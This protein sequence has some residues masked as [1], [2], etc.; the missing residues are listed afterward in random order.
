MFPF[1]YFLDLIFNINNTGINNIITTGISI[2]INI[3]IINFNID[4]ILDIELI[5]FE[6][7][8]D[9]CFEVIKGKYL[10]N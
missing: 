1:L 3:N 10:V 2:I 7:V 5:E 6:R 4:L 9:G 8:F